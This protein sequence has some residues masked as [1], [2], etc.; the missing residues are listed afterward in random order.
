V[1]RSPR[2]PPPSQV[3][4]RRSRRLHRRPVAQY[5]V[6]HHLH[7]SVPTSR[8]AESKLTTFFPRQS[9]SRSTTTTLQTAAAHACDGCDIAQSHLLPGIDAF[10]ICRLH[11]VRFN[12]ET[13]S[14]SGQYNPDYSCK[15]TGRERTVVRHIGPATV[16]IPM[17]LS[18][19]RA[20]SLLR[21]IRGRMSIAKARNELAR[22]ECTRCIF[23]WPPDRVE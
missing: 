17:E 9:Q 20:R 21:V 12:K 18:T 5:L 23:K 7:L 3:F 22:L 14:G 6:L 8:R 2:S 19:P 10:K 13:I 1:R 11:Y 15:S 4:Y 16:I